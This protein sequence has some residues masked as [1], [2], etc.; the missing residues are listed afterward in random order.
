MTWKSWSA[1]RP[2]RR[3][4]LLK[5]PLPDLPDFR[6]QLG[7]LIRDLR[8]NGQAGVFVQRCARCSHPAPNGVIHFVRRAMCE[9]HDN[10]MRAQRESGS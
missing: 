10:V 7:A 3:E 1:C 2:F 4:L 6:G 8:R 9:G 5:N